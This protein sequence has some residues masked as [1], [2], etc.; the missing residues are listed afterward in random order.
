[1][2]LIVY[3]KIDFYISYPQSDYYVDATD[4]SLKI[5]DSTSEHLML[6]SLAFSSNPGDY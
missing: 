3:F 4:A 2:S 5:N 1:M 6:N